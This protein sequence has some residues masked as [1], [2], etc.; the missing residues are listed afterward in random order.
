VLIRLEDWQVDPDAA[1]GVNGDYALVTA[2]VLAR[3]P[4]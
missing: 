4:R 2:G 3:Q 1:L